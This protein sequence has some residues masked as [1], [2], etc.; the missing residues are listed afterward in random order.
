MRLR[1]DRIIVGEVRGPEALDLLKAWNTG[2]P[3]GVTTLHANSAYDSLV[4]L[5]QLT[6]E[7]TH[8]PPVELI[9]RAIDVIVFMSRTGGIRRVEEALRLAGLEDGGYRVEPLAQKP[10]SVVKQGDPA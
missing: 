7:A 5:E 1:P 2:H 6:M 4:R 8:R 9:A 10:L 3:G